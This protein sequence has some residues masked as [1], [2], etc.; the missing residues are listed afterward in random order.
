MIHS[1]KL[2]KQN[3]TNSADSS[4]QKKKGHETTSTGSLSAHLCIELLNGILDGLLRRHGELL[5]VLLDDVVVGLLG[6]HA[7]HG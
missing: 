1:H 6:Y 7:H 5:D 2:I 3:Y 4:E